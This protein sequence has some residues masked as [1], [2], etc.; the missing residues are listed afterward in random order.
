MFVVANQLLAAIALTVVTTVLFQTGRGRYTVLTIAPLAFV[1]TT[2]VTA[3]CQ[4][5]TGRFWD[6][7]QTGLRENNWMRTVQGGLNLAC[8]LFLLIAFAVILVQAM[9]IW[10]Q[11]R[12]SRPSPPSDQPSRRQLAAGE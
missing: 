5:I 2:T 3:A 9:A 10:L 4:L 12:P 8:T 7:L 6:L 1:T 11:G